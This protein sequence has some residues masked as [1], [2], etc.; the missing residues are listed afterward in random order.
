VTVPIEAATTQQPPAP[1][2]APLPTHDWQFWIVTG[3]VVLAAVYLLSMVVPIPVL[4]ARRTRKRSQS[5]A[6]LTI[7]G[8]AVK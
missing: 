2:A 3:V 4:S 1:T 8:R 5:K 6:T 7:G